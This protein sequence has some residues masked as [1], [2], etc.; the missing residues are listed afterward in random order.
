MGYSLSWLAVRPIDREHLLAEL[1]LETTGAREEIAESDLV[2]ATLPGGWHIVLSNR[3]ERYDDTALLARLSAARDVVACFVEE[4]VM[5]S[6]ARGF[7]DGKLQWTVIHD[8]QAGLD[9]LE[10]E[11]TL[12]ASYAGIRERIELQRRAAGEPPADF[13]FE[14][15]IELA[16]MLTGFRH[17]E[18]ITGDEAEP[19]EVLASRSTE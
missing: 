12:P 2:M 13:L 11:G 6:E 14:V 16:K 1:E 18:D 8:A 17:D 4:H 7:A 19:F 3:D 9:H 15:P 5:Y 10:T